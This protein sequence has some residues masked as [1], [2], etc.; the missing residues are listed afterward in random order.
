LTRF[1][2]FG[3]G[4]AIVI[5]GLA[6]LTLVI[7]FSAWTAT[8]IILMEGPGEAVTSRVAGNQ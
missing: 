8:S 3:L 4:T 6:G 5:A 7:A 1:R 2:L